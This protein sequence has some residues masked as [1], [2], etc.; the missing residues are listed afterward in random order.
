MRRKDLKQIEKI[1]K[2]RIVDVEE[3]LELK[4]K[5]KEKMQLR[6]VTYFFTVML[7]P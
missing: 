4:N 5:L 6:D 2:L 7:F 3:K 1:W